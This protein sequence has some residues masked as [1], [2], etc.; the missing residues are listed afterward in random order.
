MKISYK[1][2]DGEI[3]VVEVDEEIG[4]FIRVSRR[5][6]EAGNRRERYHREFSLDQE[7]FESDRLQ[8]PD[9]CDEMIAGE[10]AARLRN[11]MKRLTGS[12]RRRM[13]A[14]AVG[15]TIRQIAR[16][17]GKKHKAIEDSI[18][19]SRKKIKKFLKNTSQNGLFF[20]EL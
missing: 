19:F 5:K 17:E 8:Y 6:E 16:E 4:K 20:S 9:P 18:H 13:K 10:D 2:A 11:A 14:L 15:K 3:Q 7:L 1:F 12:Q